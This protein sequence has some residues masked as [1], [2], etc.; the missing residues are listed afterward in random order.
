MDI[1][2]EEKNVDILMR[3]PALLLKSRVPRNSY[4]RPV[5]LHLQK[6]IPVHI[7]NATIITKA[8]VEM[9]VIVPIP[10]LRNKRR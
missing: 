8:I 2:W 3:K 10:M 7:L 4:L 6:E 5:G 1:V 9:E